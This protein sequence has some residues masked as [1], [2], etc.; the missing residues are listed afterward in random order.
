MTIANMLPQ[1]NETRMSIYD[2]WQEILI[3]GG[4]T[5]DTATGEQPEH[6]YACSIDKSREYSVRAEA[7]VP[8]TLLNWIY[9]NLDLLSHPNTYLGAWIEDG[10]V[11]LDVSVVL[12]TLE[13]ALECA[14]QHNQRSVYSLH[15]GETIY[16]SDEEQ[17]AA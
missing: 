14:R 12:P 1:P 16:L 7:F 8:S 17:E 13:Q 5:Y 2:L 11:Y 10:V 3:N 4:I 9:D 6:G 15:N